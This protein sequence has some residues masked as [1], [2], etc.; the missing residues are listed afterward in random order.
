MNSNKSLF[1]LVIGSVILLSAFLG[2]YQFV[3]QLMVPPRHETA[4]LQVE[5]KPSR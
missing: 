5:W 3:H 1:A 4:V 2:Y